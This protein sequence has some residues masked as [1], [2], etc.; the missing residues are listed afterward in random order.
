MMTPFVLHGPIATGR[1]VGRV[2]LVPQQ[3]PLHAHAKLYP[4]PPFANPF[5]DSQ[6]GLRQV[7]SSRYFGKTNML[8]LGCFIHR[9]KTCRNTAA[10][11][12][13]APKPCW[14]TIDPIQW[15]MP[16]PPPRRRFPGNKSPAQSRSPSKGFP[17][18]PGR[19]FATVQ[20]LWVAIQ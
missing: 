12:R 19:L 7:S 3:C 20:K 15:F 13:S 9:D 6:L 16:L 10:N 4:K 2:Y 5:W 11:A 18:P 1:S 8:S 17:I 14:R